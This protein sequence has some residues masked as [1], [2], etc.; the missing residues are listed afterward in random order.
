M[1]DR[2]LYQLG[3]L[4][5]GVAAEIASSLEGEAVQWE[6]YRSCIPLREKA[7]VDGDRVE[8]TQERFQN[9]GKRIDQWSKGTDRYRQRIVPK[10]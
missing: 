3:R 5:L 8:L 1:E 7:R 4:T 2:T 9:L 10:E 6:T